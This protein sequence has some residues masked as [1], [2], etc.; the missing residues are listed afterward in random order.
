[1]K[2]IENDLYLIDGCIIQADLLLS[3]RINVQDIAFSSSLIPI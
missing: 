2:R 1:M 3:C